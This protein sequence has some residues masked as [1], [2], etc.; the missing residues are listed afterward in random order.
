MA[1]V[2]LVAAVVALAG[3][4]SQ[5]LAT[6]R[7]VPKNPLIDQFGLPGSESLAPSDRT[8]Q[9]LRFYNLD[10]LLEGDPR[11]L[12]TTL[13]EVID[14]E[15]SIDKLHAYAE[16]SYL[17]GRRIEQHQ[18]QRAIELYGAS[19]LYAY[20][21]LFDARF[22]PQWNPYD[23][24]FRGACDLYN[25]SLEA[26]LR[27]MC[28]TQGLKPG[29]QCTIRTASGS[30]DVSTQLRGGRWRNEDFD[31][32]EFVS[33]YQLNGLRN[34][35]RT[36]GLGVPLIAVRRNYAG[37]PATAKYYPVDL[38]FPVTVLMR[39]E[40]GTNV[41]PRTG[42]MHYRAVLEIYDPLAI[43]DIAINGRQVPLESDLSTP[44]AYFLS[45]P[46]LEQLATVGLLWPETLLKT[47]RQTVQPD[48]RDPIMGLYMMQPYEPD[49]IP[50]V[51]IHG[52]WSSPVTWM[53]MFNDLQNA[54][55]I[56]QRYQFWFY[57][58]PT[59]Q[60]F[61]ISA[62]DLRRDLDEARRTLDPDHQHPALDQMVLIGHSMGGL[63]ARL[64]TL[65]SQ[66]AFWRLVSDQPFERIEA[67]P[68]MEQRL[69]DVF[70]FH[71]NASVRRVITIGTPHRGSRF[72]ND[73][74]QW[75]TSKLIT[76]PQKLIHGRE[77]LIARNKA[78]IRDSRLLSTQTSIDSLS[79]DSPFFEAMLACRR[80]P[81]VRYH[82][83]IGL[84]PQ[85]GIFGRLAAGTD[86]VVAR[87]SAHV[88][89]VESELVVE[90]DHTT[91]HAHPLA[92]LEVRRILLENL[93]DLQGYARAAPPPPAP[94]LGENPTRD[95]PVGVW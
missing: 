57:L 35:Y 37:E 45:K 23:P 25:G 69:R 89:D 52:L 59:G 93:A 94:S 77:E 9:L 28:S 44:L 42:A 29:Q 17:A 16:L 36:F 61:W 55:E 32:F 34:H 67:D 39:P 21:Y 80:P 40:S 12:L 63:L 78:L 10:R 26:A 2:L 86:G 83:V 6:L 58:Y 50:V 24:Q 85:Q 8:M 81:W 51:M 71:P 33:D 73:A 87:E 15:P 38:S 90:A 18:P 27:L 70:F 68:A 82:N 41:D 1:S 79:P 11:Q 54:P 22:A 48:R 31:R 92:V 5:R 43:A 88:T 7:S 91:V 49:K 19:V 64:Q 3:C 62:A 95:G 66:D 65:D 56:R 74:T 53:E 60:P 20:Q 30:W 75:L 13:Q 76:L 72:S 14:R 84:V 47:M 46:Q 4:S